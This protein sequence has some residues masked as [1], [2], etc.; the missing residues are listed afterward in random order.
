MIPRELF[1][2]QRIVAIAFAINFI[3]GMNFY[4]LI[5]CKGPTSLHSI[6]LRFCLHNPTVFPATFQTLYDPD[7]LQVGLKGLGYGISVTAGAAIVNALMTF[8]PKYNRELLLAS[9]VVMSKSIDI[10]ALLTPI[11]QA[12]LVYPQ[13]PSSAPSQQPPRTTRS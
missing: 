13:P 10:R 5:N 3:S 12:D 2:G 8:L 6:L 1:S 4:S 11:R 7:P 9:C